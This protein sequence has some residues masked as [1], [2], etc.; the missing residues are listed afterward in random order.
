MRNEDHPSVE[1]ECIS[2]SIRLVR[3][4]NERVYAAT[5]STATSVPRIID[6]KGDEGSVKVASVTSSVVV[7]VNNM[8]NLFKSLLF[9]VPEFDQR[10][11]IDHLRLATITNEVKELFVSASATSEQTRLASEGISVLEEDIS[12]ETDYLSRATRVSKLSQT[13][14][15]YMLHSHYYSESMDESEETLKQSFSILTFLAPSKDN[16][17]YFLSSKQYFF[18]LSA[19]I[20]ITPQPFRLLVEYTTA[21]Y[22]SDNAEE[23]R[24]LSQ[25]EGKRSALEKKVFIKGRQ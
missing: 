5:H 22:A 18:L 11:K 2:R 13:S 12:V 1:Y 6:T 20:F 19:T 24:I 16:G 25:P 8:M 9:V 14:I 15:T 23:E 7:E 4:G 3:A 10:H 17:K 21:L